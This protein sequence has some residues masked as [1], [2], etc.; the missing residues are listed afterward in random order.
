MTSS[1]V[2]VTSPGMASQVVESTSSRGRG[3]DSQR[4]AV[5]TPRH[6]RTT[7]NDYTTRHSLVVTSDYDDYAPPCRL[8]H[9]YTLLVVFYHCLPSR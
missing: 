5:L 1:V 7:H 8:Y 9:G 2:V 4:R 6:T 3:N